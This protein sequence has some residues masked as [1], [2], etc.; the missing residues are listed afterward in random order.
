MRSSEIQLLSQDLDDDN[1]A[2]V[3]VKKGVSLLQRTW[4]IMWHRYMTC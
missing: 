3:F 4:D 2:E 1:G